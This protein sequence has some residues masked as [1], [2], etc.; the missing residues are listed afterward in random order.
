MSTARRVLWYLRH[1]L[2]ALRVTRGFLFVCSLVA[3]GYIEHLR[4]RA[5]S[6]R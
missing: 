6:N 1:P 4:G 2:V 3:L 5:A